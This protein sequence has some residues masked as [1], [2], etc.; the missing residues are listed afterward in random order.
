MHK[1]VRHDGHTDEVAVEEPLEI[2]VDGRALAVTMR[3]PGDDEALALGFLHGEGLIDRPH[4]VRPGPEL[5]GNV[6]DVEGP[7][8]HDPGER[9]FYASSSCG[10]CGKGAIEQVRVD[11]GRVSAGPEVSRAL[12][13]S[14][15]ERL[16]QPAFEL[17]GGMHATGLFDASG[18]L[19]AARE[20]VGRHNAMDK[21]DRRRARRGDP[22]ARRA[23]ALRQRQALLRAR[24][25]GRR[26]RRT[27]PGR[28]RRPELARDLARR[29]AR[30][31]PV[32]LRPRWLAQ[33]LRRRRTSRLMTDGSALEALAEAKGLTLEEGYTVHPYMPSL[34]RTEAPAATGPLAEGIVG[35]IAVPTV[36]TSRGRPS[37]P[38]VLVHL[39][40]TIARIPELLCRDAAWRVTR[41]YELTASGF[42][43]LDHETVFESVAVERRFAVEHPAAIDEVFLRRLF[44][45]T[46]LDWLGEHAPPELFFELVSGRLAV[47]LGE[48][49]D[50][51]TLWQSAGRIASRLRD[52]CAEGRGRDESPFAAPLRAPPPPEETTVEGVSRI[53]W[54]LPPQSVKEAADA[55]TGK[56]GFRFGVW[57]ERCCWRAG[58]PGSCSCSRSPTCSCFG[59][60]FSSIGLAAAAFGV[61]FLIFPIAL[62]NPRAKLA[63]EWGKLAFATEF[64]RAEGLELEDPGA[65]HERWPDLALPGPVR[66][67]WRG[68]SPGGRTFRLMLIHDLSHTPG[69]SGFEGVLVKDDGAA[70]RTP[71][72]A[73]AEEIRGGGLRALV[74]PTPLP[75]PTAAGLRELRDAVDG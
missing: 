34:W 72:G 17:T 51:E 49:D 63:A 75:S 69:R 57:P 18:E 67:L 54:E 8:L 43:R 62:R 66:R 36:A 28:G 47:I 22:A 46:F 52:E 21:V 13:A 53:S 58:S 1:R 41:E 40:A 33:R 38:V 31:D 12:L 4:E 19:L 42:E 35:T 74:R 59:D 14:L 3:T 44:I 64:A 2:R 70:L 10:V 11:A 60:P 9:N 55:Y 50:L 68:T 16:R 65:V 20:D 24:P 30:H 39:P 45:P 71:E 23:P 15:P 61:F 37:R 25:E 7:L 26:R 32:R 27:G 6:V 29:R 5:E 56:V 48:G 73:P